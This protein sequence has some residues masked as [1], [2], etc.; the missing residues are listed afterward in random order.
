[1]QQREHSRGRT[2]PSRRRN[3]HPLG[4]GG[5]QYTLLVDHILSS[6][7]EYPDRSKSFICSLGEQTA[8]SYGRAFE[9]Y[10]KDGTL[11]GVCPKRDFWASFPYLREK[12]KTYSMDNF[13]KLLF[14]LFGVFSMRNVGDDNP[15]EF[16]NKLEELNDHLIQELKLSKDKHSFIANIS[17]EISKKFLMEED[18]LTEW[19]TSK[20]ILDMLN[21][22]MDP[23]RNDFT[24][25]RSERIPIEY[26]SYDMN[27]IWFAGPAVFKYPLY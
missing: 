15:N 10:P 22:I 13:N 21:T 25:I 4:R 6:W 11:V 1:M 17:K 2:L 16:K 12:V 5:C 23:E 8:G 14:A 24:M 3:P 26:E 20:N 27:E 9:V 7:N 18:F 19:L